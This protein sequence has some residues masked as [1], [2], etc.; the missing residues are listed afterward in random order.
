LTAAAAEIVDAVRALADTL[1]LLARAVGRD[2]WS[3]LVRP[4]LVVEVTFNAICRQA[5]ATLRV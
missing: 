4:E 5:H 1:I 2:E 3:V